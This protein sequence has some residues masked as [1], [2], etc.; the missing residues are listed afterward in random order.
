M[1]LRLAYVSAE[2][3]A[4]ARGFPTNWVVT[5]GWVGCGRVPRGRVLWQRPET[6]GR[7][8]EQGVLLRTSSLR[9]LS[10]AI[11]MTGASVWSWTGSQGALSHH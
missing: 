2:E 9:T 10:C 11:T 8:R 1:E 7:H 3:E 5:A 6:P 4:P